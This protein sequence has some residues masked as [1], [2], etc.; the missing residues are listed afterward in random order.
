MTTNIGKAIKAKGFTH[1]Q[2]AEALDVTRQAVS[3][4]S[5]G[6]VQPS[7]ARLRRLADVLG[8]TV[9]YLSGDEDDPPPFQRSEP[10][11]EP[12]GLVRVPILDANASCG[13]GDDAASGDIVGAIDF[14]P[15]FI[16]SLPGVVGLSKLHIVHAD[17]DS[18]EPT[19]HDRSFC[20]V[21]EKQAELRR[22]GIYCIQAD[23]Q[24]FV[25]RIQR[26]LDGTLTLIS[27]NP[28]YLPRNVDRASLETLKIIGRVVYVFS[29]KYV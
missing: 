12:S 18:M 3:Q 28:K 2:I 24:I 20:I 23:N 15:A 8:T 6:R 21:D 17:G 26:N 5:S 27:D 13:H 9:A 11:A 16:R 4:W 25:K 22:D 14:Q 29:G 10:G 19:I 7:L 1:E